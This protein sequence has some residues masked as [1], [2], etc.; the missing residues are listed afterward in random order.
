[1]AI[2]LGILEYGVGVSIN[3]AFYLKQRNVSEESI[4]I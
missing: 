4:S 3:E 1:M 2:C